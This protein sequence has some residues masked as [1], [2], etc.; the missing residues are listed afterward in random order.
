ME[1]LIDAAVHLGF[2]RHVAHDLVIETLEGSTLFAKSSGDHPAVLRN[3]VT[4]PGGT[5]AA[6]LHELESGR[7]R[8]VLSEAVWAAYRRTVELGEQLES[9]HARPPTSASEAGG[10]E[11]GDPRAPRLLA[12]FAHP[13]D[14]TFG[15][16]GV[17]ALAAA[18]GPAGLVDLHDERRRGRRG[19]R[20]R[21]P[22]D[23]SRDPDRASCD[24]RATRSAST[25][26]IFL[27]YRDSGMENWERAEGGRVRP[28][29]H[30]TRSSG[31]SS[32]RSGGCG[33]PS[34][35]PS[36]RGG[37]YGHPDHRRVSEVDHGGLR[38]RSAASPD[39]P[40]A[41]YHQAIAALLAR[42]RWSIE[43]SRGRRHAR[44]E[45]ADRGR[46]PAAAAGSSSSRGPT[47]RS[48]PASTSASVL[49]RKRAGLR[50]PRQP[51][52]P[53]RL[54]G[55]RR[56]AVRGIAGP[57]RSSCECGPNRGPG[58]QENALLGLG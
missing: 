4:S 57:P 30:A 28:G 13:D 56:R 36:I 31:A 22:R 44:R 17:M 49:D 39:A 29:R 10:P 7:L 51:A 53:R 19:R 14:E 21:R 58:E 3:M 9:Q 26:P 12:I 43:W 18:G 20:A 11:P 5:S 38:A 23:G 54:G 25:E 8:T 41:L 16:G 45:A 47:T 32:A 15:A 1:A 40:R 6:A 33:R 42:S 52:P 24:A 2:P 46:H 27:G 34:S 55:G 48:R 35:S 50:L 37:G